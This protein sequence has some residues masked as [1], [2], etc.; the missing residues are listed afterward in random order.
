MSEET[1]TLNK[2]V[3]NNAQQVISLLAGLIESGNQPYAQTRD[4][5]RA[6]GAIV[7]LLRD[8][9]AEKPAAAPESSG[10]QYG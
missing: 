4:V 10:E 2:S 3:V 6:A 7:N 1:V 5:L 9:L 8:E